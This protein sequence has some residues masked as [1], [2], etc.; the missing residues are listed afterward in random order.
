VQQY[1]GTN[2]FEEIGERTVLDCSSG[3]V[4]AGHAGQE[5]HRQVSVDAMYQP[6]EL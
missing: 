5:Y 2:W 6:E 1:F 4:D 3:S